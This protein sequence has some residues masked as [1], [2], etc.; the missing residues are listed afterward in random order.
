MMQR[1]LTLLSLTLPLLCVGCSDRV[2]TYPVSGTI[3]F[4]D[5]Q[6]VSV[7]VVEFRCQETGLSA[8]AKLDH[9]GTFSLGTFA[10]A[11]GAPAGNYQ[12]I[13]V[14]YFD[15]PLPKHIHADSD[16]DAP[17][18]TEEDRHDAHG[19][20]AHPDARVAPRFTAYSTSSLHA[21]VQPNAEN[22][23]AFVVTHPKQPLPE[24]PHK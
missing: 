17:V 16:H 12:I 3:R 18:L 2:A 19:P 20:D 11:D 13:V 1:L 9:A 8:R 15:A 5:G 10:A 23:F 21:A 24:P 7:G 22:K 14:Q 4:D 6:P